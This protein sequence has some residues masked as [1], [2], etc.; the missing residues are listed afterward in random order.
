MRESFLLKMNKLVKTNQ[1]VALSAISL[2]ATACVGGGTAGTSTA[3]TSSSSGASSSGASSS[4][5]SGSSSSSGGTT[6]DN[7]KNT[8]SVKSTDDSGKKEDVKV[9]AAAKKEDVAGASAAQNG[10]SNAEKELILYVTEG[11][12]T[13]GK[14]LTVHIDTAKHQLPKKGIK[15]GAALSDAWVSYAIS[16]ATAVGSYESDGTG[17]IDIDTCPD[18][19]GLAVVGALHGVKVLGKAVATGP[20]HFMLDGPFN[21][22]YFGGAGALNCKPPETSS[23][24]GSTSGGSSSGGSVELTAFKKPAKA[25]CDA[26]PCDGGSNTSRNCCPYM[27]CIEKEYTACGQAALPC[28]FGCTNPADATCPTTCQ[29]KMFACFA[30]APEKCDV[31]AACNAAFGPLMKCQETNSAQCKTI[32]EGDDDAA[33]ACL[34]DKCCTEMKA[35]F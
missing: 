6:G 10:A 8:A 30:A 29:T 35:A 15:L 28:F 20:A 5:G 18:K 1:L 2:L 25:T 16:S 11:S 9:D 13:A 22:V 33:D 4:S 31:S 34:F 23:S 32:S 3:A 17:T 19:E 12:K 27:P 26:N 7:T 21:L 24:S 14:V